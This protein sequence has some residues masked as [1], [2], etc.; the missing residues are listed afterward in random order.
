MQQLPK[1]VSPASE[2]TVNFVADYSDDVLP[3]LFPSA[4]FTKP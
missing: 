4:V 3:T 1:S 2:R